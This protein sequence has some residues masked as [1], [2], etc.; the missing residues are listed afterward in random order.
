MNRQELI[1]MLSILRARL[2]SLGKGMQAQLL[3]HASY[4]LLTQLP[5]R[6]LFSSY[7]KSMI[8][9]ADQKN[10]MLAYLLIDLD[11]FK[12]I[13]DSL[14]HDTGDKLLQAL[15]SRLSRALS[16][17]GKL[18]RLGGDEFAILI[19]INTLEEAE[20]LAKDILA[21]MMKPFKVED[22]TLKITA[23]LGISIY[24]RDGICYESLM[25]HADLSM[26]SAKESGRNTYCVFQPEFDKRIM[27][28]VQ[29]ENA[30]FKALK[31]KEFY[32]AYQPLIKVKENKVVGVEALLR[33]D[34]KLLGS[35]APLDFIPI[36][37]E[38]G[39]IIEVGAWVL[40]QACQQI[41]QWQQQGL[42]SLSISVNF[43]RRQL[44][45]PGIIETIKMILNKTGLL[46]EYL[47][48][49]IT[50]GLWLENLEEI[51]KTLFELKEIGIKLSIDDF[52]TGYSN[53][54]YLKRFPIDKLKI[55]QYFM[56]EITNDNNH[57]AIVTAIINL[58]HSLNLE[59]LAEG[60][61]FKYQKD[62]IFASDCDYAQGF[63]FTRPDKPDV[64]FDYLKNYP[65]R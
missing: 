2:A 22:C 10:S 29:M 38:N 45:Q 44:Y 6:T 55:D 36:T 5:N 50:E 28:Q 40:E 21:L 39:L 59:V 9:K 25:R 37:E 24:P 61:E 17:K 57:A 48:L 30:L 31:R 1:N 7:L 4:D 46:A 19:P 12:L 8:Q 14:G 62:F 18:A 56:Q 35:V 20:Q 63:Y 16:A 60:I 52:G 65:K 53:L 26:Y 58:A 51:V 49:E 54:S 11:R 13:N 47:E 43:S 32:L 27:H 33:W 41:R 64:I 23:S 3:R 15:S 34:N 42:A